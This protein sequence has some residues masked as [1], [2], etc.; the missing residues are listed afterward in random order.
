MATKPLS[1]AGRRVLEVLK[2]SPD[3]SVWA[4]GILEVFGDPPANPVDQGL[5]AAWLSHFANV[6]AR[7]YVGRHRQDTA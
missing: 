6:R 2:T 4:T 7:V 3:P 1:P 5:L